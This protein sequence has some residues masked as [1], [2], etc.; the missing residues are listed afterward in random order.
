MKIITIVGTRPELIKLSAVIKKLD[1]I[2]NHLLVHTGQNFDFELNEVFFKDLEIR[3]PDIFLNTAR[4][5]FA[6]TISE[7]I[8]KSYDV[9]VK[10]KPD[11]VLLY[12]DTNSCLSVIVA[13]RLKI[14]VFHMEAGNRCFDERVPEEL[15]RKIVDHLSDINMSISDHARSYL[16]RE[17][18]SPDTIIKIGSSMPEV[19]K[20]QRSKIDSSKILQELKLDKK[21]FIVVS[22][23]REENVD[24]LSSLTTIVDSINEIVKIYK[25]K[26]IFSVHPRTQKKLKLYGLESELIKDVIQLKPLGFNDYIKLQEASFCVISDSGTISEESSILKFPAITIRQSHERPEAMDEGTI[27]MTGFDKQNIIDSV[28][29]ITSLKVENV[30]TAQDYK[31]KNISDK[32]VK[33]IYSYV[34]YVYRNVW[35][36]F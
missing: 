20:N 18:I 14:P 28:K 7:I 27:I 16:E 12:G 29:I 19:L 6:Y 15:N 1:A 25:K 30:N 3:R 36:K 8:S 34:H 9:L 4:D 32:V 23:H 10:E 17:G 21:D 5:N 33:I 24:N 31:A 2:S 26:I 11:A 22:L 13:K 35:K